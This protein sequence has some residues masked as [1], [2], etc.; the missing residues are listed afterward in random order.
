[1]SAGHTP[2]PWTLGEW[3]RHIFVYGGPNNDD[4][5]E[6]NF[7]DEHTVKITREEAIANA[8]LFLRARAMIEWRSIETAPKDGTHFLAGRFDGSIGFGYFGGKQVPMQ[9]VVHYY[10]EPGVAPDNGDSGF[11]VSVFGG[12]EAVPMK[13]THWKP[14]DEPPARDAPGGDR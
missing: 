6:F 3:E 9:T 14:L 8:R 11:Y 7:A 13:W 1:M 2:G 12:D 5:A 10:Q 4:I